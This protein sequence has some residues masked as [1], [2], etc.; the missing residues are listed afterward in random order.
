MQ[1]LGLFDRN[2]DA[3]IDPGN[4]IGRKS[5]LPETAAEDFM[6]TES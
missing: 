2:P 4:T 1:M 6:K 5:G 3:M